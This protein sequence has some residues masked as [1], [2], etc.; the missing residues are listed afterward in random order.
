MILNVG[1]E[2]QV[3]YLVR[4][5]SRRGICATDYPAA[6]PGQVGREELGS[7]HRQAWGGGSGYY[8]I[9]HGV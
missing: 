1:V 3:L 9:I 2:W 8:Y 4:E 6:S 7:G 5:L